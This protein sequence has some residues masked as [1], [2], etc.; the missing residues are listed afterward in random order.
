MRS[1]RH[2]GQQIVDQLYLAASQK[3]AKPGHVRLIKLVTKRPHE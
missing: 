1:E 2:M 3:R